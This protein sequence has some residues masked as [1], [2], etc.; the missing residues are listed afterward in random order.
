LFGLAAL[1]LPVGSASLACAADIPGPAPF[2][3]KVPALSRADYL[4]RF[5]QLTMLRSRF[6]AV[7]ESDVQDL[8]RA[9]A[10]SLASGVPSAKQ[11]ASLRMDLTAELY[12]FVVNLKYLI[13]A[14][15]A[16]WP[17]DRSENTYRNDALSALAEITGELAAGDVLVLDIDRI[18]HRLEQ[19]N[20]WT[21][22]LDKPVEDWFDPARRRDY[23][24]E[25][26][27]LTKTAT[28]T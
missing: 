19:V 7:L 12:Y 25:A 21:E 26:L 18:L 16:I 9:E 2:E 10:Q 28:Q 20:A 6:A 24:E 13:W 8:I 11:I 15:G 27:K 22:G 1:L 17:E 23:V 3:E 14:E 4:D 5:A